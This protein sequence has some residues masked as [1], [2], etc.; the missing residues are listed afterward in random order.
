M[1]K[2]SRPPIPEFAHPAGD[3]AP[4]ALSDTPMTGP[5]IIRYH[6]E[7]LPHSPGVYRM[8]GRDG[9]ALYVG[10]AKDLKKRVMQYAQGRYH[11]HR[12][13]RMVHVTAGMEFVLTETETD[14]LLLEANLIKKMKPRFNVLM[15]DDKSF[16]YILI[17][18]DHPHP[19][20]LKHRGARAQK[21][22]YFGPFASAGAVNHTLNTLQKAFLLRTCSD[23]FMNG[24]TRP[25]MLHQIKRCAAPCVGKVSTAD[26]E[27]LVREATDFLKGRNAALSARLAAE[28]DAASETLDYEKAAALRDRIRALAAVSTH[29]AGFVEGME[30][31]D[32]FAIVLEGGVSCIEIFFYRGGQNWGN[33][34]CFPRHEKEEEAPEIL[35]SF[36]A[37]FYLDK[38]PP[39]L[40]LTSHPLPGSVLLAEAL[41]QRAG[42]RVTV[43]AP[44]RGEKRDVM[45][46]ALLNAK[47]SLGR[48]MAEAGAQ[49]SLLAGVAE[50]FG[51]NESPGR[52]E[53]YD[54]SH[55]Q[56]AHAVGAMI[57]AG[58]EGFEKKHYRKFNMDPAEFAPGDDYAMMGAMLRR[59]FARL[60][61][62]S[63]AASAPDISD[64]PGADMPAAE[65]ALSPAA[66]PVWPDLVL[67]D[68]GAGQFSAARAVMEELGLCDEI[69]L[70]AIAKGVDRDAGREQFFMEGRA[71]FRLEM[72]SPVL[73]YLQRLRDEAHRF[74]IGAHRAKRSA[75]IVKNPL[76]EIPGIG[77]ARKRALLRHFGSA[78]AVREASNADLARVEGVN[79][80]MAAR[81]YG[82]FH[83]E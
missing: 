66:E 22:A 4:H 42:H 13:A 47:A 2:A 82:F 18:R 8:L 70:V 35:E 24:R 63:E 58:P 27:A 72:R 51:M 79:A 62:D 6:A 83:P 39:A 45:D 9:E 34:A 23:S 55:I 46:H 76:D 15:R 64:T 25:C 36:I 57:V 37:Q 78:K 3:A 11:A 44:L 53:V 61:R 81:I 7:R 74:A 16:P 30:E 77:P 12:I 59:R 31:V 5:E 56:G 32:I 40:V 28:M 26:Y 68:G 73:Y 33:R 19:Q 71:P 38:P 21:G 52:I 54:N 75:A 60:L 1:P 20:L 48:R 10:K 17:R 50:L 65:P 49:A 69:L 67:I 43:H 41:S 80:A 14:A 29:Q